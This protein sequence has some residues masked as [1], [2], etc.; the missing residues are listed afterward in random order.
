[1]YTDLGVPH[2]K[3][4]SLEKCKNSPERNHVN[5]GQLGAGYTKLLMNV[6]HSFCSKQSSYNE[7]LLR[8]SVKGFGKYIN[9]SH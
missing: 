2:T 6:L 7:Q 3:S 1:M 4:I 8:F 9:R 5:T